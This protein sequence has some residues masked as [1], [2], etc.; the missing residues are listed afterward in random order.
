M[1]CK[2]NKIAIQFDAAK[3]LEVEP[4]EESLERDKDSKLIQRG[5]LQGRGHKTANRQ[6][7]VKKM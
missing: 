2:V 5:K 7:D 4:L 1:I 3:T 6:A